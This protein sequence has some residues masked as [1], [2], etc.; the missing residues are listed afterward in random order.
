MDFP[1]PV[2]DKNF[3]VCLLV[4][5][6]G[7]DRCVTSNNTAAF[8]NLFEKFIHTMGLPINQ[9]YNLYNLLFADNQVII[10]QDTGDAEYMLRK[11][12]E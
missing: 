12:V 1:H 5:K 4:L 10:V 6:D 11:L 3:A 2:R 9:D 7:G 8:R